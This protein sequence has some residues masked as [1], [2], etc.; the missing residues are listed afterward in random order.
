[1]ESPECQKNNFFILNLNILALERTL[2]FYSGIVIH[3]EKKYSRKLLLYIPLAIYHI[4]SN[5]ITKKL[6]NAWFIAQW[7]N[8]K[9][10]NKFSGRGYQKKPEIQSN[11]IVNSMVAWNATIIKYSPLW[12]NNAYELYSMLGCIICRKP[13]GKPHYTTLER[14]IISKQH[15]SG[16]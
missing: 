2:Y 3:T 6:L 10:Q 13:S 15:C 16:Q 11:G 14:H 7:F 5:L 8:L 1:M 12:M 4:G 9:I